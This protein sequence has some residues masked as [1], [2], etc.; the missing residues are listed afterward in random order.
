MSP[1]VGV[2]V[3][4]IEKSSRHANHQF[5]S[6]TLTL[7]VVGDVVSLKHAGVNMSGKEESGTTELRADGEAHPLP[8]APGVTVITKWAGSHTLET[9][10]WK[11]GQ[12]AG[13]GVYAVSAD[14]KT[15][16]ATVGGTDSAGKRFEQVIVF[17][18]G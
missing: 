6:A 15:L 2:W 17:D 11:D 3:A 14:G 12:S 9:E 1:L 16:T 13:R 10:A 5:K 4:N 18:R 8:Q 7:D